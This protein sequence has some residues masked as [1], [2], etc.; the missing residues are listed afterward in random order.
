MTVRGVGG[1]IID[2]TERHAQNDQLSAYYAG[3]GKYQF[4]S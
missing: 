1:M 4:H 3:G 2:L